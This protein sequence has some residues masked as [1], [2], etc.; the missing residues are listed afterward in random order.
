LLN[1]LKYIKEN[2]GDI[3]IEETELIDIE[4]DTK[5]NKIKINYV[6]VKKVSEI[7]AWL[8]KNLEMITL[9]NLKGYDYYQSKTLKFLFDSS[10]NMVRNI[11][12]IEEREFEG[13][14]D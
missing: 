12:E 6:P 10:I 4:L 2:N 13:S 7:I 3:E 11:F 14:E 8:K 1:Q 5:N 9:I